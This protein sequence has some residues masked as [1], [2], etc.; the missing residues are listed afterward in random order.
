MISL[1]HLSVQ[2]GPVSALADVSLNIHAGECVLVSGPSGCG[3]S[4]LGL[5]L[6]GL[7]PHAIPA[8][9]TGQI[10]IAGLDPRAL[11]AAKIAQQVGILFQRPDSQLF[12]LRVDQE[13]AFG[14]RNLGLSEDEVRERTEWALDVT[15]IRS[16]R[17]RRP[18]ELS[19]GQKQCVALATVLAMRPRV[20]ILDEPT[21][22]LDVPNTRLVIDTLKNLRQQYNLTILLI[23]HR[24]AEAVQI[25]S[26]VLVMD[27][28]Q[29]V[30]DG[31]PE[32]VFARKDMLRQFGMRRPTA[33]PSLNWE[34]LVLPQALPPQN[35][36][37]LLEL[38]HVTA[39][40]QRQAIVEDACLKLYPG[41]FAA[42]VGN[43]GAGKS[44]LG[45]VASGLLKPM[46]GQVRFAHGK[47]PRAG[48]DVAMLFQNP[49]DQLL[50]D[51]VEDEVAYAPRNF[52]RFD[53]LQHEKILAETDLLELRRRRPHLLSVGQQQRVTLA[54]CL[55]VSPRLLIL[56]EPTLGQ[57]WGHLQQ[58]MNYLAELNRQG[59]AILLISHDYKLIHRF[60][61][62]LIVMQDGRILHDGRV[63]A[64]E[65]YPAAA[66][67]LQEGVSDEIIHA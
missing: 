58:M 10:E 14:L 35:T 55:A 62:R 56:D 6:C 18:G 41:D 2:Y 28:G 64:R 32:S 29:V 21:S 22:S 53:P 4:T 52:G 65:T 11:P 25:A 9:V 57:D 23:E 43:N 16:L 26:R 17:C 47:T 61:R 46:R 20:L 24:L 3:K 1:R 38:D 54:A 63:E 33:Q 60:A 31:S 48:L 8:T 66:G 49:E 36:P 27:G 40:Y 39:G 42:L 59:V 51:N 30:A 50:C 15:G 45:L 37:P 7:I 19:G 67:N 5:A 44:T 34:D 13:V 12:H